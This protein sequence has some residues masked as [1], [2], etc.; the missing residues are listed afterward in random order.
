MVMRFTMGSGGAGIDREAYFAG[1]LVIGDLLQRGWTFPRL[2]R[3]TDEQME[4]VVAES[5]T[6]LQKTGW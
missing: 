5:L 6:H 3:I 2:A 1:W 4:H